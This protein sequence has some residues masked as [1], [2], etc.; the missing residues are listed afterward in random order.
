[1]ARLARRPVF[2]VD[3]QEVGE[4]HQPPIGDDAGL[5]GAQRAGGGVARIDGRRQALALALL[6]EP[7]KGGLGHDHFAAHFKGLRQAGFLEPLGGDGERHAAN[8]ADVGGDVF[9]DL[10]VAAGDAGDRGARRRLGR[11]VVQ[12]H[13]QAVELE[14]GG[15]FD[16]QRAGQLAHTAVPVGQLFGGVGVVQR[17]HGPR[18]AHF[19][20]ALGR[21][22][23]DALG[24]RVGG[25]QFGMRGLKA[26]ELVHQRIVCGVGD[27]RRVENVI[28]VLVTA[29][30]GAQLFDALAP[31]EE[32][33][34]VVSPM[35]GIIGWRAGQG[36]MVGSSLWNRLRIFLPGH[37]SGGRG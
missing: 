9:A 26:L 2:A 15:V 3:E 10:A 28:E 23:A 25:E 11:L 4:E 32:S 36:S 27:F 29:Q 20:E 14:L 12:R 31:R 33:G 19:F 8:G 30:L 21:L 7:L 6:V 37:A 1:M 18:V 24:G 13:A 34:L 22:A 35:G 16:R 17:E 5:E